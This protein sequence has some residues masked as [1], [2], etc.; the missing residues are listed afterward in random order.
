MILIQH[1]SR[2]FIKCN[3]LLLNCYNSNKPRDS[4]ES[5]SYFKNIFIQHFLTFKLI[6]NIIIINKLKYS[7]KNNDFGKDKLDISNLKSKFI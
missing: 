3:Y 6:L 5:P 2:T 7:C 4:N 1:G